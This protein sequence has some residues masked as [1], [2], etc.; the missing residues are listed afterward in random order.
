MSVYVPTVHVRGRGIAFSRLPIPIV[1]S[2]GSLVPMAMLA[3]L[4]VVNS[5]GTSPALL[6]GA[7]ALGG[8][9]GAI[10]L[11]VHELG[12]VR[13]ARRLRGVRPVCIS[14][15]WMG[16]GTTFEG[17]YR[18]GRDQMRVAL[19]GPLTSFV[20]SLVLLGCALVPT[21][22]PVQLGLFGLALLNAGIA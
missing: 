22:G 12:H 11:I 7:A 16:A 10:S 6:T 17:A 19:A 3:A 18:S 14:L 13:A 9:G 15:I 4:F 8:I 5:L 2:K 1:V 20:F 21:S